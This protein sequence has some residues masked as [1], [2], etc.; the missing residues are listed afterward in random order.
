MTFLLNLICSVFFLLAW[1]TFTPSSRTNGQ[2][3]NFIRSMYEQFNADVLNHSYPDTNQFHP[4]YDFIIVGAG[5]GG[6]VMAGRLSELFHWNV[7]LLEVGGDESILTD[8]PL[9]AGLATATG[10]T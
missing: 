6:S 3:I 8:I 2:E 7:L 1:I 9:I 10:K 5:S 4:E